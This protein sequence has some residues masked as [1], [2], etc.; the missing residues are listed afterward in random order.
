MPHAAT[1]LDLLERSREALTSGYAASLASARYLDASLAA[2]RAAAALV[3]ARPAPEAPGSGP[4]DVWVL[5]TRTAPE[6]AEWAQ[7]FAEVTGQRVG[8]ETGLV[9][10]V[11]READD[12]LREAE[13]FVDLVAARLGLP[14][15][16]LH[17]R[18]APVRSA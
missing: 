5:A 1:T 12:L 18:L 13:T 15:A 3:A 17:R 2:L 4:H 14:V 6:L 9:H 8:V 10:V 11:A 7:R 16:P